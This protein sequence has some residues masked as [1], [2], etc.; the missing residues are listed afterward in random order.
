MQPLV[1]YLFRSSAYSLFGH[2]IV[3]AHIFKTCREPSSSTDLQNIFPS[4]LHVVTGTAGMGKSASR[5]PFTTLLMCSGVKNVTTKKEGEGTFVFLKHKTK[6]TGTVKIKMDVNG[7]LI[8]FD[9]PSYLYTYSVWYFKPAT[10]T[11]PCKYIEPLYYPAAYN[12]D[13]G[14]S[15]PSKASFLGQISV[16]SVEYL[17]Y[18]VRLMIGT[19]QSKQLPRTTQ[20]THN[21]QFSVQNH[22]LDTTWHVIDDLQIADGSAMHP[23]EFHVLFSSPV[24]SRWRTLN[25]LGDSPPHIIIESVVPKFTPQEEAAFLN[26]VK[27]R[28]DLGAARK[29]TIQRGVELFSFIPRFV[30]SSALCSQEL[31]RLSKDEKVGVPKSKKDRFQEDTSSQLVHFSCPQFDCINWHT[32]FSSDLAKRKILRD[33]G[34]RGRASGVGF[35]KALKNYSN[36][37]L[38]KEAIFRTFVSDAITRGFIIHQPKYALSNAKV[39]IKGSGSSRCD[40]T[41]NRLPRVI[42]ETNIHLRGPSNIRSAELPDLKT[43]PAHKLSDFTED[44]EYLFEHCMTPSNV[45]LRPHPKNDDDSSGTQRRRDPVGARQHLRPTDTSN[46]TRKKTSTFDDRCLKCFTFALNVLG[47]NAVGFDS[48]LLFFKIDEDEGQLTIDRLSVM[49]IKSTLASY[50][51]I[52]ESAPNLMLI[53]LCLLCAVYNLRQDQIY[54]HLIF[55]TPPIHASPTFGTGASTSFFMDERNIWKTCYSPDDTTLET[56]HNSGRFLVDNVD[57][58]PPNVDPNHFRCAFCGLILKELFVDHRCDHVRPK[59]V[60]GSST[61]TAWTFT[62]SD[63]GIQMFDHPECMTGDDLPKQTT[64]FVFNLRNT[65]T[66]GD[67]RSDDRQRVFEIEL[68]YPEIGILPNISTEPGTFDEMDVMMISVDQ[69]V[70]PY[71]RPAAVNR[72]SKPRKPVF[73]IHPT[74]P[75]PP[76][77]SLLPEL[78]KESIDTPSNDALPKF[79]LSLAT[80]QNLGASAATL[81]LDV[82]D[83]ASHLFATLRM[84]HLWV[85]GY[86]IGFSSNGT[87]IIPGKKIAFRSDFNNLDLWENAMV[88]ICPMHVP[89]SCIGILP[90]FVN[91]SSC[92]T[93]SDIRTLLLSLDKSPPT[94]SAQSTIDKFVE[95]R[96]QLPHD[97]VTRLLNLP[98]AKVP[99]FSTD[100]APLSARIPAMQSIDEYDLQLLVSLVNGTR[101]HILEFLE[102][103]CEYLDFPSR[104]PKDSSVLENM[105]LRLNN[106]YWAAR[107]RLTPFL[108]RLKTGDRMDHEFGEDWFELR[109]LEDDAL[110]PRWHRSLLIPWVMNN[111]QNKTTQHPLTRLSSKALTQHDRW[112][113]IANMMVHAPIS[114]LDRVALLS[115]VNQCSDEAS[116]EVLSSLVDRYSE[117]SSEHNLDQKFQNDSVLWDQTLWRLRSGG[118][119]TKQETKFLRSLLS[120]QLPKLD[121]RDDL[122]VNIKNCSIL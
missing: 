16:P 1:S 73:T 50:E 122:I 111:T 42:G 58:L 6:N 47:G 51:P 69:P 120:K 64:K 60:T 36:H 84:V 37:S 45:I 103:C 72:H 78:S 99:L 62:S 70:T 75:L 31:A 14:S 23:E 3:N 20:S 53:W 61:D 68:S 19:E 119:L 17:P 92:F 89:M 88:P 22:L 90:V 5:Y 40:E 33:F 25:R 54:P 35:L 112:I 44:F 83:P 102:R 27:A 46:K 2:I 113:L 91:Q 108:D 49:F 109:C 114:Q 56:I 95:S 65:P 97:E 74:Q 38:K 8:D 32:E 66:R 13:P 67:D 85:N 116:R 26:T 71:H 104:I 9:P 10:S 48:I 30:T 28:S 55:V 39:R 7:F 15:E 100:L 117:Q 34:V 110:L 82:S 4:Y 63:I 29:A 93:Q 41:D 57:P 11:D 52:S 86:K 107:H 115:A 77:F 94:P 96:K 12:V 59:P 106:G 121:N 81:Q 79:E 101:N 80:P 43:I 87:Q 18:F 105:E 76:F 21:H 24:A 118:S 98:A